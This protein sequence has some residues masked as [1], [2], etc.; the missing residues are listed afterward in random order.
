MGKYKEIDGNLITLS[1][2]GE[3]DVIT[4]G[5]N[6][7]CVQGAGLAPQMVKHFGTDTFELEQKQYKGDIKKLGQIDYELFHYSDL[8]NKFERYPDEDNKVLYNLYV[9]NS[10]TQ[11]YYGKN[12]HD[13]VSKPL[14][15]EA[16]TL[17]L[18]KINFIFHGKRIGLPGLIGC[19][20]AGGDPE[21]VKNIIKSEMRDCDV[22][23]VYLK[24]G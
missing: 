8:D 24:K 5:C 13:G 6:C 20:L 18:R 3:F 23:V 21:I 12:H 1:L 22:T 4:H 2:E 10:Y 19:G 16:L 15:Y 7:Q 11:Y 17:C 9:V 14:D